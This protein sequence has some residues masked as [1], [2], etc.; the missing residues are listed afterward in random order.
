MEAEVS[1]QST[2][3]RKGRPVNRFGPRVDK[4]AIIDTFLKA[5]DLSQVE[6]AKLNDCDNTTV[7]KVLKEYGLQQTKV[8]EFK[9]NRADILAGIQAKLLNSINDEDI[10]KAPLGTRVL[11]SC[12]LFDKER[13]ERDLSTSNTAS[14][15]ADIAALK[16][17]GKAE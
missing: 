7:C 8:E 3:K 4:E 17:I 1:R 11:A 10:K 2:S 9:S 15:I 14:V 13:L 16:G 12:Q 6:I 5:P